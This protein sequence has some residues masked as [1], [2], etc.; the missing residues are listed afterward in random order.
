MITLSPDVATATVGWP[1]SQDPTQ[2][3]A[4]AH[5]E[6]KQSVVVPR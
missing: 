4:T 3:Q 2:P 5:S 1:H 6:L